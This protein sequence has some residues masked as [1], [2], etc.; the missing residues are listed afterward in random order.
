MISAARIDEAQRRNSGAAGRRS[1][2][3]G[4]FDHMTKYRNHDERTVLLS[5]QYGEHVS[6]MTTEELH[7][8]AEI[9]EELAARDIEIARLRKGLGAARAIFIERGDTGYA[10]AC[11][12]FLMGSNA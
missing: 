5:Q 8:K 4:E 6:A 7:G 11:D 9:A 2:W 10:A 3:N 1:R 12:T